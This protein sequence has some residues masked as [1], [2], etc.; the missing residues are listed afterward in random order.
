MSAPLPRER[1]PVEGAERVP[2]C[3]AVLIT[4]K[5]RRTIQALAAAGKIPGA[6]KL[7]GQWSFDERRL[8]GW[9]SEQEMEPWQDDRP[10]RAATGGAT[11][12]GRGK[13]SRVSSDDGAYEQAMRRLLHAGARKTSNA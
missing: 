2:I 7:G 1:K 4:G 9:V 11:H 6:A 3:Q 10:R 13:W 5:R 12:S 8:R